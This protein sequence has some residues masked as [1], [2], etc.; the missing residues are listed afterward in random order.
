MVIIE[1]NLGQRQQPLRQR[2]RG[3]RVLRPLQGRHSIEGSYRERPGTA[4]GRTPKG[5]RWPPT[6][7]V[8]PDNSGRA[9]KAAAT[10]CLVRLLV[11]GVSFGGNV[12]ESPQ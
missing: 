8:R 9:R 10:R 5:R 12:E 1:I 6:R 3:D 7:R 2:C 11:L 4:W